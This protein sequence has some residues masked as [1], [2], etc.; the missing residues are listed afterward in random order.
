MWEGG[1]ASVVR[2]QRKTCMKLIPA[3]KTEHDGPHDCC[4]KHARPVEFKDTDDADT[5]CTI[6]CDKPGCRRRCRCQVD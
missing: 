2:R 6:R 5:R 4:G 1:T 3:G